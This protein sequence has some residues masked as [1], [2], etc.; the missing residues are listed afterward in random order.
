V[1]EESGYI[2]QEFNVDLKQGQTLVLEKL[3]SLYT[4]RYHA[5]SECGLA[6]R[7]A[8]A[9]S[10]CFDTVMAEHVLAWKFL[11]RRFEVHIQPADPGLKSNVPMLLRL[12]TFHLLQAL[13]PNTIGLDIGLDISVPAR[14]WTGEAY[15][16]HIF[17]DELFI[18]PFFNFLII[19]CQKSP[20][21][22]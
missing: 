6:A 11:W 5:I 20:G 17:W 10:G 13:S 2:G 22:C 16:G 19:E 18:F 3:T 12:N 9:R 14:G 1:I 7:K 21:H 8:I 15:Q 4:S